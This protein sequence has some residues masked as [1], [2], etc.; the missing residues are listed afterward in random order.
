MKYEAR[1]CREQPAEE[2]REREERQRHARRGRPATQGQVEDRE[3]AGDERRQHEEE[4]DAAEEGQ[5]LVVAE[6]RER[7]VDDEEAVAHQANLREAPVGPRHEVD[8]DF[9]EPEAAPHG[10]Y[11]QLGLYLEAAAEERKLFDE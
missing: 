2:E 8:R 7:R 5:R 6:E 11:R 4:P 9:H 3:H 1:S 10:L